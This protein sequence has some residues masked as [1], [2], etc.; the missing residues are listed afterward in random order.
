[1]VGTKRTSRSDSQKDKGAGVVVDQRTGGV[2]A[3][4]G[5][6]NQ[7]IKTEEK[8]PRGGWWPQRTEEESD[9]LKPWGGTVENIPDHPSTERWTFFASKRKIIGNNFTVAVRRSGSKRGL[10]RGKLWVY[11]SRKKKGDPMGQEKVEKSLGWGDMKVT[12]SN[13]GA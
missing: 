9:C 13:G 3:P 10:N 1:V 12:R 7:L 5:T 11:G 8:E 2:N 6:E 4:G